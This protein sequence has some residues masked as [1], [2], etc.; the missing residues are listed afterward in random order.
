MAFYRLP[1]F[2]AET[3]SSH[4][5][6]LARR[7][8]W[9]LASPLWPARTTRSTRVGQAPSWS[10]LRGLSERWFRVSIHNRYQPA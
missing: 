3:L 8:C 1:G 7:Q 10:D 6:R 9:E 5:N 2:I 4:P